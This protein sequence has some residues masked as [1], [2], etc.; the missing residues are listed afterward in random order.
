M[1][2]FS[3][4]KNGWSPSR[5]LQEQMTLGRYLVKDYLT[6]Q[7]ENQQISKLS[8][9]HIINLKILETWV[10]LHNPVNYHVRRFSFQSK[11][12]T[13][14]GWTLQQ[15]ELTY[16]SD[17]NCIISSFYEKKARINTDTGWQK[18]LQWSF[19]HIKYK[20]VC[21]HLAIH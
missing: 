19:R 1:K 15:D 2:L 11:N 17:K 20:V 10:K 7:I 16:S 13:F 18:Y 21:F 5:S 4:L 8:I 9:V 3:L 14:S 12:T 6:L